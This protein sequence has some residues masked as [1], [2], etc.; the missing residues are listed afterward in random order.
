MARLEEAEDGKEGG[1][2][3]G[4]EGE[5]EGGR[6]DPSLRISIGNYNALLAAVTRAGQTTLVEDILK[7]IE[8]RGL[9]PDIYTYATAIAGFAKRPPSL[10]P[11][12]P[13]PRRQ[14]AQALFDRA[15]DQGLCPSLE[16]YGALMDVYAKE[17]DV[18][19]ACRVFREALGHLQREGG[20]EGGREGGRE[21][22]KEKPF[23]Y[24][25]TSL[26]HAFN[27]APTPLSPPPSPGSSPPSSPLPSSSEGEAP[28]P[29]A[30]YLF[31]EYQ[32]GV[33]GNRTTIPLLTAVARSLDAALPPSR[34]RAPPPFPLPT[35]I[36][37]VL[38]RRHA[39]LTPLRSHWSY[40]YPSSLDLHLL[41]RPLA[42]A[43]VH[44][45]LEEI[46]QGE[47]TLAPE[48]LQIIVGKSSQ[49]VRGG[50]KEALGDECRPPLEVEEV[51][52]N[53][54][55]LLVSLASVNAWLARQGEGE[56]AGD[57]KAGGRKEAKV[58]PAYTLETPRG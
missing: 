8:R 16:M 22:R 27:T 49:V 33:R 9:V 26:I 31:E 53:D 18:P 13:P 38:Y 19:G 11:S 17:G 54:G 14:A 52:G 41:T 35:A 44:T 55:R 15:V 12:L 6:V 34:P 48:G 2:E 45:A 32:L 36:L 7:R 56:G 51:G 58:N 50:V 29:A 28:W 40:R 39:S 4:R 20:K 10:P 23:S 3:G 37:H 21:K 5:R 46:R 57:G 43:A 1:G 47:V 25:Y 24:L 30:L 42:Q